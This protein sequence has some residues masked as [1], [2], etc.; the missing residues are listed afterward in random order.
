M[1]TYPPLREVTEGLGPVA[2]VPDGRPH[3]VR[4]SLL[5]LLL[6]A[7]RGHKLLP[8]S[9]DL[10]R[11]GP[12]SSPAHRSHP[13]PFVAP[14]PPIPWPEVSQPHHLRG[15]SPNHSLLSCMLHKPQQHTWRNSPRRE[16]LASHH[17]SIPAPTAGTVHVGSRPPQTRRQAPLSGSGPLSCPPYPT[18]SV[19]QT[20]TSITG[21]SRPPTTPKHQR[22]LPAPYPAGQ[23]PVQVLHLRASGGSILAI[24]LAELGQEEGDFQVVTDL[25]GEGRGACVAS[26][27][28]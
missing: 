24:D 7:Q 26:A 3:K 1:R 16:E 11:E 17:E 2:D 5:R 21:S 20:F 25:G 9:C 23:L 4:L 27:C 18:L 12:D 28:G 22:H 19:L 13:G 15:A 8:V 6:W 10:A 14:L